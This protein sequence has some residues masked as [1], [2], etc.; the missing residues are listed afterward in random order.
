MTHP[1]PVDVASAYIEAWA[2]GDANAVAALLDEDVAFDGPMTTTSGRDDVLAAI[3]GFAEAVTG[4]TVLAALG[5][6]GQAMLL[7]DMAT[8]PFG[9]MRAAEHLTVAEGRIRASRLVFDTHPVRG[10]QPAA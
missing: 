9:M 3:M 1:V 10:V 4:V 7:Y 8:G 6:D 2:R 5:D